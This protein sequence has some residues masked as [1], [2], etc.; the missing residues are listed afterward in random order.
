MKITTLSILVANHYG[1]LSRIANLFT[2]RRLNIKGF[3]ANETENPEI[4]R[5]TILTD[6]ADSEV[7][8]IRL[9]LEKLED[10]LWA[11]VIPAG[12]L[13]G[14]E[15]ILMKLPREHEA[16]LRALL[17][18]W[19]GEIVAETPRALFLA[20]TDT[21]DQIEQFIDEV[22]PYGILELSRTGGAAL[23]LDPA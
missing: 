11:R 16:E 6:S 13:V 15:T 21:V 7:E 10:V 9:L 4:T 19:Q 23:E 5:I 18:R 14:R 1:V 22:E 12:H 3:S 2:R 20:L 8:Q 17:A